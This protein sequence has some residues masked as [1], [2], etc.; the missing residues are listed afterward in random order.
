MKEIP[1]STFLSTHFLADS[2]Y[3]KKTREIKTAAA[4]EDYPKPGFRVSAAQQVRKFKK[5][6]NS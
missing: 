3:A 5:D 4:V 6:K 1:V 2:K